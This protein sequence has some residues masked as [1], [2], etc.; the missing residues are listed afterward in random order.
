MGKSNKV[1]AL[2]L[3]GFIGIGFSYP[4]IAQATKEPLYQAKGS[5]PPNASRRGAY[6][7]SSSVDIGP[8][9]NYVKPTDERGEQHRR[10]NQDDI[11][12]NS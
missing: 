6:T 4:F 5:L 1:V 2:L 9:P 12:R 8:D 11:E 7:N 3:V 10:Q